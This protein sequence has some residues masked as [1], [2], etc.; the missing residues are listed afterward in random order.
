MDPNVNDFDEFLFPQ[1]HEEPS[2]DDVATE[3]ESDSVLEQMTS[4]FIQVN[5]HEI[6]I[7]QAVSTLNI[8]D[9]SE[10]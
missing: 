9:D 10:V 8:V 7:H 6:N 4:P 2:S 3:S 5:H 1:V